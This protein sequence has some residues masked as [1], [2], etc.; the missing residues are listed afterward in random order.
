MVGI[1][2]VDLIGAVKSAQSPGAG[3]H[4]KFALDP[5]IAADL[6]EVERKGRGDDQIVLLAESVK[7]EHIDGAGI[8]NDQTDGEFCHDERFLYMILT[9]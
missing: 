8:V 1:D 4:G 3:D 5:Q 2:A 7:M 9:V 6:A